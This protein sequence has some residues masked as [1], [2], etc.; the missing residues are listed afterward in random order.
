LS[1]AAG[2]SAVYNKTEAKNRCAQIVVF[3]D[4]SSGSTWWADRMNKIEGVKLKSELVNVEK[5]HAWGPLRATKEVIAR[6]APCGPAP[7]GNF[8]NGFTINPHHSIKI[9]WKQV[10]KERPDALAVVYDRTNWVKKVMSAVLFR[11]KGCHSHNVQS[12][13]DMKKCRSVRAGVST[14]SFLS[15]LRGE[16]CDSAG[17]REA[18]R[19]VNVDRCRDS[20]TPDAPRGH[21]RARG[22]GGAAAVTR[23]SSAR[24]GGDAECS[25]GR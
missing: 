2:A 17:L 13:R 6:L 10:L 22:R 8:L 21:R 4:S 7:S 14:Q 24:G 19:E 3:K 23:I 9:D 1:L 12:V 11:Q 16:A 20:E 18:A 5:Q 15:Q 25:P